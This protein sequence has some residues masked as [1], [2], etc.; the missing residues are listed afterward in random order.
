M[1]LRSLEYFLA[2][3]REGNITAAANTLHVSQPALSRQVMELEDEFG[4]Q[5][6]IRKS[7][8]ISLTEDGQLLRKRAEEIAEL[9]KKTRDELS[10]SSE[11]L[12]GDIYIGAGEAE[13]IHYLTETAQR[14]KADNPELKFHIY[15]GNTSDVMERLNKGLTDLAL[16]VS[17]QELDV[18]KYDSISL[19]GRELWGVLMPNQHPLASK[20]FVT[21]EDIRKEPLIVSNEIY[22]SRTLSVLT[23]SPREEVNISA[24]YS[25]LYNASIL[26]RDGMGIAIGLD[27]IINTSGDCSLSFRPLHPAQTV[28]MSIVWKRSQVFSTAAAAYLEELKKHLN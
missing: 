27:R 19:P 25:L 11:Y 28:G 6:I 10:G 12:T 7:R 5:L 4:K 9:V 15:S 13:S 8:G 17:M 24:T 20:A 14:L 16:I 21:A 2:I 22:Q 3:A 23:E 18:K 1:E 26:V